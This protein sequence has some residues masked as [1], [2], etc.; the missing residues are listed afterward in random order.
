M[1]DD[2]F[3]YPD[4][5]D[6]VTVALIKKAPAKNKIWEE[7]EAET[8]DYGM[9]FLTKG[10]LLIDA[11]CGQGR[12]IPKFAWLYKKILAVEPD[13]NRLTKAKEFVSSQSIINVEF[14]NVPVQ[15]IPFNNEAN[16]ILSSHIIQHVSTNDLQKLLTSIFS[17]LKQNGIMLLTTNNSRFN[18]DA[19]QKNYIQDGNAILE[20]I[21]KEEFE[22][23]TRNTKGILPIHEFGYNSL[24]KLIESAGFT[25]IAQHPFHM[26][27]LCPLGRDILIVLKNKHNYSLR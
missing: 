14:L 4:T 6:T 26:T 1:S 27:N 25:L 15:E 12:L 21:T 20:D 7:D 2:R 16:T 24:A 8:I 19:Y 22:S 3:S 13:L 10:Q 18:E 5:E 9:Q 17:S 23:L 11:G